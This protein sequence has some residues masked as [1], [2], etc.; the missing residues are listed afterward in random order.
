[1]AERALDFI[2]GFALPPMGDLALTE[3]R[4]AWSG[5]TLWVNFPGGKLYRVD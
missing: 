2:E 1:V 4:R 3:A 5:K